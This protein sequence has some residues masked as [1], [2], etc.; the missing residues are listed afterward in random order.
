MEG[1]QQQETILDFMLKK[2]NVN[3]SD[4][5]LYSGFNEDGIGQITFSLKGDGDFLPDDLICSGKPRYGGVFGYAYN[6]VDKCKNQSEKPNL[7][8]MNVWTKA[9]DNLHVLRYTYNLK[10]SKPLQYID[11]NNTNIIRAQLGER[12]TGND[13]EYY[14][15]EPTKEELKIEHPLYYLLRNVD[16]P[17]SLP[18]GDGKENWGNW[19]KLREELEKYKLT[20]QGNK[21]F[22]NLHTSGIVNE[23]E[24]E[25]KI[26]I[27]QLLKVVYKKVQDKIEKDEKEKELLKVIKE[28]KKEI[29]DIKQ[30]GKD[31]Q[32]EKEQLMKTEKILEGFIKEKEE[33]KA[34]SRQQQAERDKFVKKL[35]EKQ[36]AEAKALKEKREKEEGGAREKE[37]KAAKAAELQNKEKELTQDKKDLR[38]N[39]NKILDTIKEA[40]E[41]STKRFINLEIENLKNEVKRGD[42]PNKIGLIQSKITYKEKRQT[43][44]LEKWENEAKNKKIKINELIYADNDNDNDILEFIEG[45]LKEWGGVE[46]DAELVNGVKKIIE[47]LI[48]TKFTLINKLRE[49]PLQNTSATEQELQILKKEDVREAIF[50]CIVKANGNVT[51]ETLS[52]DDC[53]IVETAGITSQQKKEDMEIQQKEDMEI[54]QIYDNF[55]KRI[56][57]EDIEVAEN[58]CPSKLYEE[59]FKDLKGDGSYFEPYMKNKMMEILIKGNMGEGWQFEDITKREIQL[60]PIKKKNRFLHTLL[61]FAGNLWL[62]LFKHDLII[63][64]NKGGLKTIPTGKFFKKTTDK[65]VSS[66]RENQKFPP[67]FEN[68]D[69]SN[70]IYDLI[71]FIYE[72]IQTKKLADKREKKDDSVAS[73]LLNMWENQIQKK[74]PKYTEKESC[75]WGIQGKGCNDRPFLLTK[76]FFHGGNKKGFFFDQV[77]KIG[78]RPLEIRQGNIKA[79]FRSETDYLTVVPHRLEDILNKLNEKLTGVLTI[80]GQSGGAAGDDDEANQGIEKMSVEELEREIEKRQ[81]KWDENNDDDDDEQGLLYNEKW[82]R[83]WKKMKEILKKKKNKREKVSRSRQKVWAISLEEKEREKEREKET[84]EEDRRERER[85]TEESFL[86]NYDNRTYEYLEKKRNEQFEKSNK[87]REAKGLEK[88]K[89]EDWDERVLPRRERLFNRIMKGEKSKQ[90]RNWPEEQRLIA[91]YREKRNSNENRLKEYETEIEKLKASE[92]GLIGEINKEGTA[93]AISELT[94][95]LKELK[96]TIKN[97]EKEKENLEKIIK[98]NEERFKDDYLDFIDNSYKNTSTTPDTQSDMIKIKETDFEIMTK[99][100]NERYKRYAPDPLLGNLVVFQIAIDLLELRNIIHKEA[101][102]KKKKQRWEQAKKQV[103][104]Y[105]NKWEPKWEKMQKDGSY[106]KFKTRGNTRGGARKTRRKRK[107]IQKRKTKHKSRPKNKGKKTIKLRHRRRQTRKRYR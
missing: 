90:W 72:N 69:F 81:S 1:G 47:K 54:Q 77:Q 32:K 102:I 60:W 15:E 68:Q 14:W 13:K 53:Q 67:A 76:V 63:N 91:V 74:I 52:T 100:N 95:Q 96:K 42:D 104:D 49:K 88:L 70:L 71:S 29:T 87:E 66:E 34:V 44:E 83:D 48:E 7:Q 50:K 106:G 55:V 97:Q 46:K 103:D 61:I 16:T 86:K 30:K 78:I 82:K 38:E 24:E 89:R 37:K 64:K 98:D 43:E 9:G 58:K 20:Q 94:E 62:W 8:M 45:V 17:S 80:D 73:Y 19:D 40:K 92:Q 11:F 31:A 107:Y 35:N 39:I 23:I 41:K 99:I 4:I 3:G 25:Y 27:N 6:K 18:H 105:Y 2:Y 79:P 84:E 75:K 28:Q 26:P 5:D 21:E 56:K 57:C 59:L 51:C 12:G 22:K 101:N 65:Y 10:S 85:D 36:E 33:A 93:V